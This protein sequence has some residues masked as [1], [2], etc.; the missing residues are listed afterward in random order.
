MKF[1]IRNR[2]T[3]SVQFECELDARYE[4]EPYSIQLGAAVKIAYKS[5]ADL[6]DADL[7]AANLRAADLR[8]ANLSAA[9][10]RAADLSA[11]NLRAA[12]LSDADLTPIRDDFW[13][14]LSA[15]PKEVPALREALAEGRVDGS[16]YEGECACLVGTIANVRG[17]NYASLSGLAPNAS[18]PAERFFMNIRKGD[19]PET[20]Q[21]SKIALEWT[22]EWLSNM[23]AA[24]GA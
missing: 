1:Q 6:S 3:N 12:D 4:S 19:K 11:A 18:R 16:S 22:D 20:N 5:A 14:V 21:S 15:A 24:F 9:N 10:L 13:A 7:S 2:W 23:R 17:V 8:A